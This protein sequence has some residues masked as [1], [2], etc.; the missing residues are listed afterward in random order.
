M[1]NDTISSR[2][3]ISIAIAIILAAVTWKLLRIQDVRDNQP[4]FASPDQDEEMLGEALAINGGDVPT[5]NIHPGFTIKWMHAV[6][7]GVFKWFHD[8]ALYS[9]EQFNV[10][11]NPLP[12]LREMVHKGRQLVVIEIFVLAAVVGL[13]C[14]LW[15]GPWWVFAAGFSTFL[16]FY[17]NT[18]QSQFV[19]SELNSSMLSFAG[20]ALVLTATLKMKSNSILQ[21][22]CSLMGGWFLG[23]G[24]LSKIMGYP[25]LCYAFVLI[26]LLSKKN[27]LSIVKERLVFH[28]PNVNRSFFVFVGSLV[29]VWIYATI[30]V[31]HV[32]RLMPDNY[33]WIQLASIAVGLTAL[34]V[35]FKLFCPDVS[36]SRRFQ[37]SSYVYTG[38]LLALGSPVYLMKFSSAILNVPLSRFVYDY[39]ERLLM[40][41]LVLSSSRGSY[42]QPWSQ[43][44]IDIGDMLIFYGQY[45]LFFAP[46]LL[47]FNIVVRGSDYT[48]SKAFFWCCILFGAV[49][50]SFLMMRYNYPSYYVYGDPLIVFAFLIA[51]YES[52]YF[53]KVKYTLFKK[54]V[55]VALV[56]S[57][58]AGVI[59]T[60]RNSCR[61]LMGVLHQNFP[62]DSF[63]HAFSG[64]ASYGHYNGAFPASIRAVLKAK[65][66]DVT[67]F[68]NAIKDSVDRDLASYY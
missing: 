65:Y 10:S 40:S 55:M 26:F 63:D 44:R 7:F 9:S 31:R 28:K 64:N 25:L 3:Q 53:V 38:Y 21:C 4:W 17:G 45:F 59:L 58:M 48:R 66:P 18:F 50:M 42:S 60:E 14:K 32:E 67:S 46:V 24:I 30:F 35:G 41:V 27:E 68:R 34:G 6:H 62:S 11:V 47:F 39:S 15:L 1:L 51:L 33:I 61:L 23:L 56:L 49:M 13:I 57:F 16:S 54:P 8:E 37:I 22:L 2:L 12:Q 20:I 43:I 36:W 29:P 52:I 19:R 5:T